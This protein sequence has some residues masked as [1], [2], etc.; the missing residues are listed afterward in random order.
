MDTPLYAQIPCMELD[1][2]R[3][4]ARDSYVQYEDVVEK[5]NGFTWKRLTSRNRIRLMMECERIGIPS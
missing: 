2:K 1:R 4:R 3:Y 5:H